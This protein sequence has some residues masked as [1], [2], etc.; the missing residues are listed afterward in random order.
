M[1]EQTVAKPKNIHSVFHGK[2]LI[3]K[4]K[5]DNA[6]ALKMVDDPNYIAKP[7]R[8]TSRLK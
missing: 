5:H 3:K 2:E 4:R 8:S 6:E 1:A 7:Y